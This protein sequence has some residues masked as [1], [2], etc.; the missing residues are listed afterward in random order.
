MTTPDPTRA[1][2]SNIPEPFVITIDGPTA[3]GKGTV[4]R[5]VADRL[6]FHYLDSGAL[7]RLVALSALRAN[8]PLD[9]ENALASLAQN[10]SCRFE[11]TAVFLENE[12]VSTA[13]RKEEVGVSASII[14]ALPRVRQELVRLQTNFK[15]MPGLVA[16]GRD[17]GTTLFPDAQLKVFL[18]ASVEI[19]A[20]RRYKQLFEKGFTA[21]MD[22]LRQDLYERDQRDAQRD[23]APL[24]PA[25]DAC[26]L[27]SSDMDISQ[28]VHQIL[29]WFEEKTG[30]PLHG[31]GLSP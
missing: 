29:E 12:D 31:Q 27:D 25:S 13:I 28:T 4:A 24:I 21:I 20:F 15:R 18:T 6:G 14:A 17:M 11:G 8:T 16:D 2:A 22:D 1:K 23:V 3:S 5:L 26:T 19:R 10:M 30:S 7:Y 9:D